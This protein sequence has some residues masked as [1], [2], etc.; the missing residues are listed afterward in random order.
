M[1][2]PTSADPRDGVVFAATGEGFTRLAIEA[3]RSLRATNPGLAVD[4]FTDGPVDDPVFD[5]VHQLG[6]SWFRPKFEAL[7]RSRFQR[8]ICLDADVIIVA[9]LRDVFEVL[10][11]F[12]LVATHEQR[13][14]TASAMRQ[15]T[16]PMPAAFPQI[17]GGMIGIRQSPATLAFID[18]VERTMVEG[19]HGRDQ[20]V[21]REL[22]FDSDLRIWVLPPEYNLMAVRQVEVQGTKFTAPRVLHLPRLHDHVKGSTKRLESPAAVIGPALW[23]HIQRMIAADMTLGGTGKRLARPVDRGVFGSLRAI[24]AN[25]ALGLSRLL[26]R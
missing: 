1:T 7:R 11:R 3:A 6:R 12:D 4:L 16:R 22:L 5:R 26:G 14:N 23:R 9:D 21:L 15:L 18:L 8:T 2:D 20:Y 13:R 17:N 10:G 25:A 24:S 19:N